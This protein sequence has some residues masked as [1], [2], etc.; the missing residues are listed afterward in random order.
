[1]TGPCSYC[2]W[3]L[4]QSRWG[5]AV[6]A[7]FPNLSHYPVIGALKSKAAV[8]LQLGSSCLV[9]SAPIRPGWEAPKPASWSWSPCKRSLSHWTPHLQILGSRRRWLWAGKNHTLLS[10]DFSCGHCGMGELGCVC[11]CAHVRMCVQG[12]REES[13]VAL[14]VSLIIAPSPSLLSYLLPV[15]PPN[16]QAISVGVEEHHHCL[17]SVALGRWAVWKDPGEQKVRCVSVRSLNAGPG[18]APEHLSQR[19]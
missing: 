13:T 7:W 12:G 14:Y 19:V 2:W 17:W 11:V 6:A 4:S 18:L 10:L 16:Y 3:Q 15:L 8:G 1:M 5:G 9:E